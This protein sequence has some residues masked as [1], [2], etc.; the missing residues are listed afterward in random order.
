M[1]REYVQKAAVEHFA[2]GAQKTE[3]VAALY[4]D[5]LKYNRLPDKR[6]MRWHPSVILEFPLGVL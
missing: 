3:L 2:K 4:N 6:G 1:E 5:Q